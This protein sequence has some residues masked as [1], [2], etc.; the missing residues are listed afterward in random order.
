MATYRSTIPFG[1][2]HVVGRKLDYKGSVDSGFQEPID[3]FYLS[4]FFILLF[5]S[6]VIFRHYDQF[7]N[8]IVSHE[9]SMEINNHFTP[10]NRKGR[11]QLFISMKL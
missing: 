10:I 7:K 3:F 4:S 6:F 11:S 2:N 8:P 1:K 9:S 5:N